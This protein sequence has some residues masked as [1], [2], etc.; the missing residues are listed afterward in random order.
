MHMAVLAGSAFSRTCAFY[1]FLPHALAFAL[2]PSPSLDLVILKGD[3]DSVFEAD[4][5]TS[6]LNLSLDSTWMVA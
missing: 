1:G 6:R 3:R 4:A 5:R 2:T